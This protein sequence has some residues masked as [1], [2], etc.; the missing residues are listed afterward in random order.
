MSESTGSAAERIEW[1]THC[2]PVLASVT[3]ELRDAKPFSGA[4]IGICLHVEPKTAVLLSSLKDLGAE[5]VTTGNF[6]TTQDDV[7]AEL[8][9][10][11]HRVL[12]SR[13]DNAAT[14]LQNKRQVLATQ[15]HLLLDNGAEL[16]SELEHAADSPLIGGTEETTSGADRL[17]A[18][19]PLG[20]PILVINDSP[21]KRIFENEIG[22]G[23]SVL[24]TFQ[25]VTNSTPAGKEVVVAGYGWC[26]RGIA[27]AFRAAGARVSILEVDPVTAFDAAVHG[28]AVRAREDA[29]ALGQIFI[30]ATG[31][32]NVLPV[33]AIA[34]MRPGALLA[35]AGHFGVEIDLV[36]LTNATRQSV[37]SPSIERFT[38]PTGHSGFV[39]AGG[40]MLNLAGGAGNPIEPMDMGLTLQLLCLKEV[41]QNS[42]QLA[43]G[44]QPVPESINRVLAER[45]LAEM[46]P[47]LR[48]P[49]EG[50]EP[51]S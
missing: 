37:V 32:R 14:H 1:T 19:P 22:V 17:R 40:E 30:T 29:I 51:H 26:G 31:D 25:R 2:M 48:A 41:W 28:S 43:S 36:G 50:S 45:M 47:H 13:T 38:F 49:R 9:A 4:R 8:N 21:L 23:Q 15:P 20:I 10:R 46:A 33:E 44:A 24:S 27:S 34:Q 39:L 5:V 6:G 42:S 7:V 3:D 16:Y 12:G 18:A 11:G 35:N